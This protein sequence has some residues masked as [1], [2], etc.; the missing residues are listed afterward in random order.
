MAKYFENTC[1]CKVTRLLFCVAPVGAGA[2]VVIVQ[3]RH[4]LDRHVYHEMKS[5]CNMWNNHAGVSYIVAPASSQA[6][7]HAL[8]RSEQ[9]AIHSKLGRVHQV[10]DSR[11][12]T[13]FL[14]RFVLDLITWKR[15]QCPA[16]VV[17]FLRDYTLFGQSKVD[18]ASVDTYVRD[19]VA[20]LIAH[21]FVEAQHSA[22]SCQS[23]HPM[24]SA[25]HV[26]S[27]QPP[28]PAKK[29]L[30]DN[31]PPGAD[32]VHRPPPTMATT[33]A[34]I[35]AARAC[36]TIPMSPATKVFVINDVAP[37]D[38]TT[39]NSMS[40]VSTT[41]ATSRTH[42]DASNMMDRRHVSDGLCKMT[43][44]CHCGVVLHCTIS[45]LA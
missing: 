10:D 44:M 43:S 19:A 3:Y 21:G 12:P 41:Q 16:S 32:F 42:V 30:P 37:N 33:T 24:L 28:P 34:P 14:E 26:T 35:T 18:V 6:A 1:C 17:A 31:F 38:I 23:T 36:K 5:N 45:L 25:N 8:V 13:Q 40:T 39:S 22:S 15:V 7:V 11:K 2:D 9:I 27:A 4:S 20:G 29:P